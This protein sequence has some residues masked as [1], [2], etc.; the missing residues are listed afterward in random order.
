MDQEASGFIVADEL[1][2]DAELQAL[3]YGT[4]YSTE[5]EAQSYLSTEVHAAYRSH[6]K[7]REVRSGR[8]IE[9]N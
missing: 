5:E 2:S 3:G 4:I 6:Y 1:H 9:E 7:I 8:L